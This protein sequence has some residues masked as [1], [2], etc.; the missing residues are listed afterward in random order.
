MAAPDGTELIIPGQHAVAV[1]GDIGD[2]EII[3]HE[4]VGE[5]A[6]TERK[7]HKD[8]CR[9]WSVITHQSGMTDGCSHH[10]DD[11]QRNCQQQSQYQRKISKFRDHRVACWL[12]GDWTKWCSGTITLLLRRFPFTFRVIAAPASFLETSGILE[13]LF[14]LGRH[15]LLIVLGEDLVRNKNAVLVE[16]AQ[17]N[18][19]LPFTEQIRKNAVVLHPLHAH[20]YP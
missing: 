10:G 8:A 1:V 18:H 20:H 9:Q 11:G 7:Q 5:T 4:S 16:F 14:H 2:R 19:A 12:N 15:V 3:G 17:R 13:R 6:K